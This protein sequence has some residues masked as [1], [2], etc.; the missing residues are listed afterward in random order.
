MNKKRTAGISLLLIS[1]FTSLTK[2]SI[3]G[4][5]IGTV[6]FSNYFII[7]SAVTFVFGV[8]FLLSATL[9]QTLVRQ[10]GIALP[11]Q[12]LRRLRQ[13]SHKKELSSVVDSSA[14]IPYSFR[15]VVEL[16]DRLKES[17]DTIIPKAVLDEL[18]HGK[19]NPVVDKLSV[20]ALSPVEGYKSYMQKAKELL[21]QS[22]KAVLYEKLSPFITAHLQGKKQPKTTR[23]KFAQTKKLF[24]ILLSV[25]KKDG[26]YIP[27]SVGGNPQ[28]FYEKCNDYLE[29][30]CK[31]SETDIEVMATALAEQEATKGEVAI[32]G[33]DSDFEHA[34]KRFNNP[35]LHYVPVD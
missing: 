12:V 22:P 9:E 6:S 2:I 10:D 11:Q 8:I 24:P 27:E 5:I 26:Y 16:I 13:I 21:S 23:I 29:K 34:V 17:G 4:S 32:I 33:K 18:S 3:T 25:A 15:G 7:I 1:S 28:N 19:P 20:E 14:I 31:V 30:H 35:Q